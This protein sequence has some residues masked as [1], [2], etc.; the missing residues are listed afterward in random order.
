[1]G[2]SLK[3]QF[4]PPVTDKRAAIDCVRLLL[5]SAT[6]SRDHYNQRDRGQRQGDGR[7]R[8][9]LFM[10]L[11]IYPNQHVMSTGERTMKRCSLSQ[12]AS[13]L[14]S[15]P[16]VHGYCWKHFFISV[17]AFR[18]RAKC[19]FDHWKQIFWRRCLCLLSFVWTGETEHFW[20]CWHHEHNLHIAIVEFLVCDVG[21][22]SSWQSFIFFGV[23]S[24]RQRFF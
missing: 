7:G 15:C 20:K 13:D 3:G 5:P 8:V 14:R 22:T 6:I 17:L 2:G 4:R 11:F 10:Y 12:L 24:L 9:Y 18:P 19:A 1:M 23:F 21:L 16:H